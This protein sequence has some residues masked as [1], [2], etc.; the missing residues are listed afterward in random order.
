MTLDCIGS[1]DFSAVK[2]HP[3]EFLVSS[4]NG[5]LLSIIC[6]AASQPNIR[7]NALTV[8]P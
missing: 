5:Y 6:G 2:G 7:I 3:C 8:C 4:I 1:R